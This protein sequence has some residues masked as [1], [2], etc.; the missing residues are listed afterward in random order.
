MLGIFYAIYILYVIITSMMM[1]SMKMWRSEESPYRL[2]FTDIIHTVVGP[3]IG[4]IRYDEY[5]PEIPF[6][7][8]H[9]FTIIVLVF[10]SSVSFWLSRLTRKINTPV[11]NMLLSIGI[12]QGMIVCLI[13]TIHFFNFLPSGLAFP[14]FGFEL[15]TPL[16][17]FFLLLKEFYFVN[18]YISSIPQ[19]GLIYLKIG[20]AKISYE[21]INKLLYYRGFLYP[22]MAVILIIIEIAIA[23]FF[24]QDFDSIIKAFTESKGFIF[25]NDYP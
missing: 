1:I 10:V 4:F 23:C 8:E 16:I 22:V 15:L 9:V 5:G 25:S 2:L 3:I 11:Q 7:K 14:M 17:A 18:R 20:R 12:F 21:V 6:S 13:T 19:T 24:G